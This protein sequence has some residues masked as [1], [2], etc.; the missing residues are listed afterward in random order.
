MQ[1][2]VLEY[3]RCPTLLAKQLTKVGEHVFYQ[4][5]LGH[6]FWAFSLNAHGELQGDWI[7]GH[8]VEGKFRVSGVHKT[9]GATRDQGEG[10]TPNAGT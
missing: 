4:Q 1:S 2:A 5:A 8:V 9:I 7:R 3:K 6:F 10:S